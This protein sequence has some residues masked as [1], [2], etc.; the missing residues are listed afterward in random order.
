MTSSSI[1]IFADVWCPFTHVGLNMVTE[2]RSVS[3][4]KD[5]PLVVRAWPLEL[6]NGA[7][8]DADKTAA[9][10]AAMREQLSND[11]FTGFDAG[12]FPT[13][14]LDALDLVAQAYEVSAT[15]GEQASLAVRHALFEQGRDISDTAVLHGIADELGLRFVADPRHIAVNRDW[16]E[17]RR[18]GVI[19][20]PH[21]YCGVD[22]MFCPSLRLSRDEN[23]QLHVAA[24]ADRL[25]AFISHCLDSRNG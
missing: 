2:M 22:D 4:R 10:V 19:G 13:S 21:F 1:E 8:M 5:V 25:R 18:R 11:L 7:P 12:N 9:N 3:R 15:L 24:D 14:T 20:S 16:D 6:V 17:G 23:S